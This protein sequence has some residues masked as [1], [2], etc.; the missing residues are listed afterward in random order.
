M[1]V[2]CLLT[3]LMYSQKDYEQGTIII[4]I[5]MRTQNSKR[6]VLKGEPHVKQQNIDS[7]KTILL[8]T[9]SLKITLYTLRLF[10]LFFSFQS[11]YII[12]FLCYS[13]ITQKRTTQGRY[14]NRSSKTA[15]PQRKTILPLCLLSFSRRTSATLNDS[16]LQRKVKNSFF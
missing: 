9:S 8:L 5:I 15:L 3:C 14:R 6:R 4:I 11:L 12:L 1:F 2:C 10:V 16:H 7:F 13:Q